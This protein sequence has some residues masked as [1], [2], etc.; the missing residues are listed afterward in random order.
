MNLI[1]HVLK[2]L[3][4]LHGIGRIFLIRNADKVKLIKI[5]ILTTFFFIHLTEINS[6]NRNLGDMNED[7]TINV[8]DVIVL[9]TLFLKMKFIII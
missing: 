7:G 2:I 1:F 4:I 8:V 3:V 6:F 5:I 9:Q